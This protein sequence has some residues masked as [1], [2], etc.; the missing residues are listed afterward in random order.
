MMLVRVPWQ[1]HLYVHADLLVKLEAVK[2]RM[3]RPPMLYGDASGWRSREVQ[4]EKWLKFLA[5]GN[6]ASDPDTGNRTHMRG[7]AADLADYSPA[8]QRACIA[9]G[10]ER[11][12][13]EAWHWQ[14][15]TWRNYPIIPTMPEPDTKQRRDKMDAYVIG[16]VDKGEITEVSLCHETLVGPTPI[17]RGYIV[18]RAGTT[19]TGEKV[20]LQDAMTAA[21]RAHGLGLRVT[22]VNGGDR[23]TYVAGQELARNARA[24]YLRDRAEFA[25]EIARALPAAGSTDLTPVLE[26]VEAVHVDVNKPRTLA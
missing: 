9:V 7:V 12:P 25:A 17:E 19:V 20:S 3:G 13:A 1:P 5:G 2:A 14:L 18:V 11:D 10:L 23:A 16:R 8:M 21:A 26:A 24:Q 4:L 22:G 15:K 6:P